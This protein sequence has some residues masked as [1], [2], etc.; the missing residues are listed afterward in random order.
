MGYDFGVTLPGGYHGI[1]SL[2]GGTP[3]V[4]YS[5]VQCMG[6]EQSLL[7]CPMSKDDE[8]NTECCSDCY[9]KSVAVYCSRFC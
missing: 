3:S 4:M 8:S 9:E 1:T 7:D 5:N 2:P 6:G